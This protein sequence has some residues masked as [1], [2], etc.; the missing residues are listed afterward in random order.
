[1]IDYRVIVTVD[2][3]PGPNRPPVTGTEI[4]I[5]QLTPGKNYSVILSARIYYLVVSSS[6]QGKCAKRL[7]V[8]AVNKEASR[9]ILKSCG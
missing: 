1:M 8:T 7:K 6:Q 3:A 4:L 2:G 5:E 9:N